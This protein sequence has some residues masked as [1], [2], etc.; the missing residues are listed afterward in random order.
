MDAYT[1]AIKIL[2]GRSEYSICKELEKNGFSK[3]EIIKVM[4]TVKDIV[5][6]ANTD[7]S[8]IPLKTIYK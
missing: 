3:D 5:K 7:L 8:W 2:K 4:A 6:N 1:L